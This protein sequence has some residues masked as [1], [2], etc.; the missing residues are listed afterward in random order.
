[1][2][3]GEYEIKTLGQGYITEDLAGPVK[4]PVMRRE[5][6]TRKMNVILTDD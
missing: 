3:L 5:L 4:V 2:R 6:C 1:M